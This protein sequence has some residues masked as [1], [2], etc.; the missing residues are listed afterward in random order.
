MRFDRPRR[1]AR[2]RPARHLHRRADV[3]RAAGLPAP[4]CPPKLLPRQRRESPAS[5]APVGGGKL[6]DPPRQQCQCPIFTG[7]D[8]WRGVCQFRKKV[9]DPPARPGAGEGAAA[10][11]RPFPSLANRGDEL[12]CRG[13]SLHDRAAN[14]FHHVSAAAP[15]V[16]SGPFLAAA[17]RAG[18]CG[19]NCPSTLPFTWSAFRSP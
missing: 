11:H 12:P 14:Q 4:P 17:W 6:A 1:S 3:R 2:P 19:T 18:D 9:A 15:G 10:C 13:N 7:I 8:A 5:G 16:R